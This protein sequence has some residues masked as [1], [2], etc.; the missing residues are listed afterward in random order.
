MCGLQTFLL[1]SEHLWTTGGHGS[2]SA[3]PPSFQS[4]AQPS[5]V[6][7]WVSHSEFTNALTPHPS[8]SWLPSQLTLVTSLFLSHLFW[9]VTCPLH[10]CMPTGTQQPAP[11]HSA[12][13]Q[14]LLGWMM[15]SSLSC[16]HFKLP[17][18]T[19]QRYP[20]DLRLLSPLQYRQAYGGTLGIHDY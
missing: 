15:F 17:P 11:F 10:G 3:N 14:L 8:R 4:K 19:I 1:Q 2:A 13:S 16:H 18:A 20:S 9:L 7:S 6:Q 12:A 5:Q